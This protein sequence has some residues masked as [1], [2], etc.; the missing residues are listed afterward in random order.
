MG[1]RYTTEDA[2]GAI[3][4]LRGEFPGCGITADL[5]TGFPGETDGEFADTLAFIERCEFSRM[6]I[7]PF[8]ARPGTAAAA[9]PGQQDK[10]V[11]R[12]RAAAARALA[13]E[14]SREF[15]RRNVGAAADVLFESE[16]GDVSSGHAGNYLKVYARGGGMRN[17]T[18]R[19]VI[20]R[21]VGEDAFGVV[22]MDNLQ[23]RTTPPHH[24]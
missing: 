18:R 6:H 15:A 8:S 24:P 10:N 13:G 16:S 21:A 17:L 2:A 3:G 9:M 7:F 11:R 4:I 5:I 14:M 22:A 12:A 19:V 23:H 1:R 20:T